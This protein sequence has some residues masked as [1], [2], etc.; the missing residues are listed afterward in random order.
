MPA[1]NLAYYEVDTA[2]DKSDSTGLTDSAASVTE[3]HIEKRGK[4][5]HVAHL[6]NLKGSRTGYEVSLEV[7][8]SAACDAGGECDEKEYSCGDSRVC[9]VAADTAEETLNYYDSENGAYDAVPYVC[10]CGE[11]KSEK[12]TGY[13]RGEVEHGLSLLGDDVEEELGEHTYA[14]AEEDVEECSETE[15]NYRRNGCGSECDEHVSHNGLGGVLSLN[16]R[17]GRYYKLFHGLSPLLKL[18]LTSLVRAVRGLSKTVVLYERTVCR[19]YVSTAATL[20]TEGDTEVLKTL[21]SVVDIGD[22]ECLGEVGGVQSHGTYV[23]A[24]TAV[25]TS[26][27]RSLGCILD[28]HN[29]ETAGSLEHGLVKG[30][31]RVTHHRSAV[32]HLADFFLST[33]CRLDNVLNGST[34]G[35][36]QILRLFDC[37]TVYGYTSLNERHTG[38]NEL[39]ESCEGGYVDYENACVC[40]ELALGNNDAGGVEHRYSLCALRIERGKRL[41]GNL[42]VILEYSYEL[43]DTLRL[44]ILYREDEFLDSADV[45][46]ENFDTLVDIL[47]VV[48]HGASVTGEVGLTLC[49]VD[50]DGANFS[51]S[52]RIKLYRGGEACAAKTYE[53]GLAYCREEGVEILNYGGSDALVDG[54]ES[55]ALN[56]YYG[57]VVACAVD[58]GIELYNLTG[59]GGVDGRGHEAARLSDKLTDLYFV[60]DLNHGGGRRA[61]MLRHREENF[62]RGFHLHGL[63]V[64]SVLVVRNVGVT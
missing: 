30:A 23:H 61:E 41:N 32:E 21:H 17:R 25:D 19:T 29:G 51:L 53:T 49:A 54:H 55:V 12:E 62:L 48:E 6:D 37:A 57:N 31:Y 10:A 20:H 35:H 9:E 59:N 42:L 5:G 24:L 7:G 58:V 27:G 33:A 44:V 14:Y 43:L 2:E 50:N 36:E 46:V 34:D 60:T 16:V 38:E 40:R 26:G 11:V 28:V 4:S 15:E 63:H 22:V 56:S 18:C 13:R 39:C 64:R 8:C 52:C 1:D 3:E 47:G 45:L